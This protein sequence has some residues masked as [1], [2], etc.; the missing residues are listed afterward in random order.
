LR[1][2]WRLLPLSGQ[3]T[4]QIRVWLN[5]EFFEVALIGPLFPSDIS[6]DTIRQVAGRYSDPTVRISFDDWKAQIASLLKLS[7][8]Q[9]LAIYSTLSCFST[10]DPQHALGEAQFLLSNPGTLWSRTLRVTDIL[11]FLFGV[12]VKKK[13][14]GIAERSNFEAF[15]TKPK[16]AEAS[17]KGLQKKTLAKST[18]QFSPRLMDGT[19]QTER[20]IVYRGLERF[21]LARL[22]EFLRIYAPG[23]L[24]RRHVLS[25]RLILGGG[26]S[27][28][29]SGS[30]LIVALNLFKAGS[31]TENIEALRRVIISGLTC[32]DIEDELRKGLKLNNP[33]S[34]RPIAGFFA[35][36]VDDPQRYEVN[37]PI[38][39]DNEYCS[40]TYVLEE[41]ENQSDIFI[42]SCRGRT[43]YICSA[44]PVVF[45]TNCKD[46]VIF[47]GAATAVRVEYCANC[48]VIA[49]ARMFHVESSIRCTVNLLVNT[50]PLVTGSCTKLVLAPYNAL[51]RK[52][53]LDLLCIGINPRLNLW[54]QPLMLASLGASLPERM[55]PANFRL[56]CLPF[57][58][59]DAEPVINALLPA[60]YE[61]QLEAR[62]SQI[63]NL[64]RYLDVIQAKDH[65]LFEVLQRQIKDR[66]FAWLQERGS[67]AELQWVM[68]RDPGP[69]E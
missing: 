64:K 65:A 44:V 52:L 12:F 5:W 40:D 34:Y 41:P 63:L 15:P 13:F 11:V 6:L 48:R 27:L 66:A 59:Q 24:T 3:M 7:E 1:R 60:E 56:L 37:P 19:S 55:P 36:T 54:D 46:S 21:F 14:R 22:P 32:N 69:Q 67:I 29:V 35:E 9:T 20:D 53:G 2:F 43:I 33:M 17:A 10:R 68:A 38:I 31:K 58:W 42:D 25:L 49:A 30:D 4:S 51:Y 8:N 18:P 16:P 47:V 45:I 50:R 39:I 57:T 62:R 26:P 61:S 23:G 28:G